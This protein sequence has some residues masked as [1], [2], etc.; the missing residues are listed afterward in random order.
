MTTV[1]LVVELK[2]KPG[3]EHEVAAFLRDA[4]A[5]VQEELQTLSWIAVKR[6]P[7]SFAI[8]DTFADEAGRQA[9]L[10]APVAAAL[11]ERADELFAEPPQ[12]DSVD[13]LAAKAPEP[14]AGRP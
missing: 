14:P 5:L 6:N 1:G 8:I 11:M 2:A 3:K 10:T 4:Q 7:S 9:H 13:L 12:I